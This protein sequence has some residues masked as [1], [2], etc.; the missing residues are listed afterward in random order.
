MD[1]KVDLG[2]YLL[3][4]SKTLFYHNQISLYNKGVIQDLCSHE[5][6]IKRII[7]NYKEE[8]SPIS[9]KAN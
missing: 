7:E 5:E 3:I 9:N 8:N 1:I 4:M 2:T 6:F